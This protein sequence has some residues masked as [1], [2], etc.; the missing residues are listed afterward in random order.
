MLLKGGYV[1]VPASIGARLSGAYIVTHDSDALPGLSNRFAA[2]F[3]AINATAMPAKY[4]N[5]HPSRVKHV[6]LPVDSRYRSYSSDEVRFLREKFGIP[7]KSKVVLITGGSNGARR[8]NEWSIEAIEKLQKT[9]SDLYAIMIVG[10][11]N[12]T[13]LKK[14]LS[15]SELSGRLQIM[16]FS[17]ELYHLAAVS[18]VIITRAGA[19]TIAEFAAGSKACILVPNPDL[20]GGHQLKNAKVYIDQKSVLAVQENKLLDSVD[21]LVEAVDSLLENEDLRTE[22]GRNLNATLLSVPAAKALAEIL[23]DGALPR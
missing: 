11:G 7:P 9:H 21:P 14:Q 16:E 19:T 4:Y 17:S 10:K 20:T 18:D 15:S 5:Y 1:C 6:G 22:L 3:A 13:K 8:L 23:Y 2:R 12:A